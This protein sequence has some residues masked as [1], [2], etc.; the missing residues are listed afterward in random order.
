M[1]EI[2][3]AL[4][5]AGFDRF[6]VPGPIPLSY[7]CMTAYDESFGLPAAF[8]PQ[9]MDDILA[10]ALADRGLRNL[11]IAETEKYAHVTYFFNGG[12]EREFP[13]ETRVLIPSPSVPTYDLLPEMSADAVGKRAVE[14]IGSGNHD[15]MVL[16]F[17]NCDM[18]GHTGILPAAIRAVE[19]VDR[20]VRRVVEKVWEVGGVALVTADHGNAEMMIDPKTGRPHTAHTTNLVPLVLADPRARGSV[21]GQT[22][23][24][25]TS[26]R[27]S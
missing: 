11:R 5:Q 8:P 1:R 12:E 6:A 25:R 3:R 21:S 15:L 24:S 27:R 7:A 9:T 22:A 20:N 4:T 26:H 2:T 13:G 10:R 14:E 19:A 16:N 18:V 17:A 23:P